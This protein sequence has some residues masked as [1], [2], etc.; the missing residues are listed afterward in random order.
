MKGGEFVTKPFTFKGSQLVMNLS[1]SAAGGVQ[2]E[3]QD[4]QGSPIE[5]FA[6]KDCP[7][8][9]GDSTAYTASW[10]GG[11]DIGHLEGIPIRLRFV[12]RD[13]DLYSIQFR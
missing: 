7:E 8:I 3:I 12:M 5:G 10:N 1:T 6:L 13:S 9:F 2:I 4:E 11:S